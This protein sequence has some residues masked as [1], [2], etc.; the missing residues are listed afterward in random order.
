MKNKTICAY[1]HMFHQKEEMKGGL[2]PKMYS[3]AVEM[4]RWNG[5][6]CDSCGGE[7]SFVKVVETK[8][9]ESSKRFEQ[10]MNEWK[11]DKQSG[12]APVQRIIKEDRHT[13]EV[14]C[15]DCR[16]R[17][18]ISR[19]VEVVCERNIFL[20]YEQMAINPAWQVRHMKSRPA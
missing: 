5:L 18:F 10:R 16:G 12:N 19:M 3:H 15:A 20:K 6:A 4:Q 8:M 11:K 17:G 9:M 2:C 14:V 13:T 1:C 7:G